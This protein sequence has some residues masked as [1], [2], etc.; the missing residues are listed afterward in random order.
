MAAAKNAGIVGIAIGALTATALGV[1]K[2]VAVNDRRRASRSKADVDAEVTKQI[3]GSGAAD[4][5]T[6][7]RLT[8]ADGASIHV[9]SAGERVAERPAVVLLHGVTL[10]AR[11]WAPV[12]SV[13]HKEFHVVAVDWRGHG[14]SV[15]G[16]AGYGLHLLASD[17][18][19]VLTQLNL[20]NCVVVGHSMGGMALMRFCGNHAAVL[21]ERVAGLMFL[22]TAASEVGSV[23]L[24]AFLRGG[25]RRLIGMQAVA[26]RASWTL[27]GD[28]GYSMVRPTFGDNPDP[29]GVEMARD[30]VSEMDPDATAASFVPLLSHDAT[31]V[32][33][34]ITCPVTVVVGTQ[35]RLTPPP[36]AKEIARLIKQARLVV[37]DGPG[38]MIMLERQTEF[39]ELVR[40][41]ARTNQSTN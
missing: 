20:S 30:I 36:Q 1:A 25:F 32:L 4:G 6:H 12:M 31:A 9:V 16:S 22:S 2:G 39:V 17:L 21:Q 26:R 8:M 28:L 34:S 18:A 27:P 5:Y 37:L 23:T 40:S 11:L 13:L 19:E 41:L 10:S 7:H 33:P 38:H 35:D 29:V 14:Q 3:G 24:P 15:A